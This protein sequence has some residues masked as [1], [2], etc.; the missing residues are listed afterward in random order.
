M[1][2]VLA[3]CG[4][5]AATTVEVQPLPAHDVAV[6]AP[7]TD[8]MIPNTDVAST[9]ENRRVIEFC[10]RY[11][12]ALEAMDAV[13]LLRLA[14]PHYRSDDV[15]YDVLKTALQNLMKTTEQ[16]RY[17]IRYRSVERRDGHVIVSITY[18]ASYRAAGRVRHV[19]DSSELVLEPHASSFLILSGM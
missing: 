6:Q 16:I 10:E 2:L 7:S 11:R 4:A 13:E 15:T 8:A 12:T 9:P 14:S 1:L 3:A 18:S 19:T 17:E 5:P